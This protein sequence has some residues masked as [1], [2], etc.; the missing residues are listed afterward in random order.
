MYHFKRHVNPSKSASVRGIAS[1]RLTAESAAP[2]ASVC[3]MECF[4]TFHACLALPLPLSLLTHVALLPNPTPIAQTGTI[5]TN[6]SLS[7]HVLHMSSEVSRSSA[8]RPASEQ[9]TIRNEGVRI[10]PWLRSML[11]ASVLNIGMPDAR[12]RPRGDRFYRPPAAAPLSLK[13]DGHFQPPQWLKLVGPGCHWL[14]LELG[15]D[16]PSTATACGV[17]VG[18][19]R[20]H[21]NL[22]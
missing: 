13:P 4:M 14:G 18:A 1:Q 17:I 2:A 11:L 12:M 5:S 21:A 6:D 15:L 19:T 3:S 22:W 16:V 9:M 8:S 7:P 10:A 20:T